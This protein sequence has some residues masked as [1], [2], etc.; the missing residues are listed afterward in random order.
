MRKSAPDVHRILLKAFGET[1]AIK[2]IYFQYF[3]C[4]TTNISL[5]FSKMYNYKYYLILMPLEE[6]TRPLVLT[7]DNLN[8]RKNMGMI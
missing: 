6:F 3:L 7:T 2:K 8:M 4:S 1:A 5:T